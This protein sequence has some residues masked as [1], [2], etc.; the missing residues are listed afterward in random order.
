MATIIQV[1]AFYAL[2]AAVLQIGVMEPVNGIGIDSI[3]K[4]LASLNSYAIA[5]RQGEVMV[6]KPGSV[7]GHKPLI[8]IPK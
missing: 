2:A 7:A 4:G 1:D 5:D 6:R 8:E 3:K